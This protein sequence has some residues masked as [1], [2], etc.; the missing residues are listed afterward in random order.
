[1]K[2]YVCTAFFIFPS[3]CDGSRQGDVSITEESL[4]S[5]FRLQKVFRPET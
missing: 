5:P 4:M 1:M 2:D 3:Y